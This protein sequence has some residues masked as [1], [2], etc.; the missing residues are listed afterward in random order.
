MVVDQLARGPVGH[1]DVV[2]GDVGEG[3]GGEHLALRQRETAGRRG[4]D[5]QAGTPTRTSR[6]P[7]RVVL[8]RRP[9]H[10]RAADVDLLD[11]TRPTSAPD[12]T[13]SWN[14]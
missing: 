7:P 6:R 8:R 2:L 14:G 1:R 5:H 10:R 11:A 12:A 3:A 13:V 9:D 4:L